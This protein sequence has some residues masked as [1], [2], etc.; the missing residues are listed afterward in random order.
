MNHIETV[1]R[2]TVY[3]DRGVGR[4]VVYSSTDELVY[5]Q[6]PAT[7]VAGELVQY[8]SALEWAR[9]HDAMYTRTFGD[10]EPGLE[11]E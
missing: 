3:W 1:G 11:F 8:T 9:T 6:P 10:C 2:Y 7:F 5:T 4:F